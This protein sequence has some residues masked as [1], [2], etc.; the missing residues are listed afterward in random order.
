M[1]QLKYT[2]SSIL[3]KSAPL[4]TLILAQWKIIEDRT[5][6]DFIEEENVKLTALLG[7]RSP[8]T[9]MVVSPI[10]PKEQLPGPQ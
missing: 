2:I 1:W 3:L 6:E 7:D 4:P 9:E 10:F 8:D 5:L